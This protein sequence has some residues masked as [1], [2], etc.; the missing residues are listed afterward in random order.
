MSRNEFQHEGQKDI[1]LIK[2]KA[3]KWNINTYAN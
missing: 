3:K 2:K 1:I